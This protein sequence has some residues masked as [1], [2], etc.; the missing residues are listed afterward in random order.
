MAARTL[1]GV[2]AVDDRLPYFYTDQY[3]LGMEYVG[4]AE[5]DPAGGDVVLRGDVAGRAFHAFWLHEGRVVA[6]MHVNVWDTIDDVE[7]LVRSGRRVDPARLADTS[8]PL[9]ERRPGH[10]CPDRRVRSRGPPTRAAPAR[11]RRSAP[12]EVQRRVAGQHRR[13]PGTASVTGT[14]SVLSA[15]RSD[16]SPSCWR[17]TRVRFVLVRTSLRAV[18][19]HGWRRRSAMSSRCRSSTAC[20]SPGELVRRRGE[21]RAD[22]VVA[23]GAVLLDA[24]QAQLVARVDGRRAAE[25]EE[26]HDRVVEVARGRSAGSRSG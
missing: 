16:R 12:G 21:G 15:T 19:S 6:G 13:R 25:R 4:Y 7:A 2:D 8:V 14:S 11:P 3:D 24:G 22:G 1:Q 20:P 5:P 9:G 18:C 17:S 10:A 23:P 26:Q